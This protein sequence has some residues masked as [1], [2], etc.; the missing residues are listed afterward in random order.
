MCDLI[1]LLCELLSS[2]L[3]LASRA[4]YLLTYH[5]ISMILSLLSLLF[6]SYS[7]FSFYL[8][9]FATTLEHGFTSSRAVCFIHGA[10]ISISLKSLLLPV[11][12]TLALS[13]VCFYYVSVESR[14][15]L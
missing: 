5:F 3:T 7:H 11:C 9:E 10:H 8:N 14:I 13:L 12:S 4:Y 1:T 15:F 6:L 2:I